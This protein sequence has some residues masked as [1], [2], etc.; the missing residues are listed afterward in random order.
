MCV[1]LFS[2]DM[3]QHGPW[4]YHNVCTHLEESICVFG[5][6]SSFPF[7]FKYELVSRSF[8]LQLQREE[9]WEQSEDKVMERLIHS[10]PCNLYWWA[11][12]DWN[13][14]MSWGPWGTIRML[15]QNLKCGLNV[16]DSLKLTAP[17]L[18]KLCWHNLSW[19]LL[20]ILQN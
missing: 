1:T 8:V 10:T 5:G 6:V 9:G 2:D 17:Y 7:P 4:R 19:T 14:E 12:E 3:G 16:V 20:N 13:E 15:I 11:C 18:W